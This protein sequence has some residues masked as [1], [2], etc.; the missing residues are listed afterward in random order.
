MKNSF[1]ILVVI[2]Y[3]FAPN[4]RN[5]ATK[6]SLQNAEPTIIHFQVQDTLELRMIAR[7]ELDSSNFDDILV[8]DVS[9]VGVKVFDKDGELCFYKGQYL[10]IN[11]CSQF[12]DLFKYAIREIERNNAFVTKKEIKTFGLRF[13]RSY[14]FK[15]LPSTN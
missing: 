6:P 2:L 8:K 14:F 3:C 15:V 12:E 4:S 7:V 13:D 11:S 1:L 9:I 5:Q 10:D